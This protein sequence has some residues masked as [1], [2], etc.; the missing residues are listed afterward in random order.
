LAESNALNVLKEFPLPS[1]PSPTTAPLSSPSAPIGASGKYNIILLILHSSYL[2]ILN[3]SGPPPQQQVQFAANLGLSLASDEQPTNCYSGGRSRKGSYLM[4]DSLGNTYTKRA[5][6]AGNW[7]CSKKSDG[8]KNRCTA[9][10]FEKEGKFYARGPH[11]CIKSTNI[12]NTLNLPSPVESSSP[13]SSSGD[14][15]VVN[16]S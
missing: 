1:A 8:S 12:T 4:Q 16:K 15:S 2:F 6:G 9:I 5:T 13:L 7:Q 14:A 11:R 10:L 3:F